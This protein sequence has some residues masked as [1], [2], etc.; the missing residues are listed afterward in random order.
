MSKFHADNVAFVTL[1]L[2]QFAER[3]AKREVLT[4][5]HRIAQAM[6]DYI[7]SHFADDDEHFPQYTANLHDATGVAIYDDG[8]LE[9][10]FPVQRAVDPQQT[11]IGEEEWGSRELEEA[12]RQGMTKF[13]KGLWLVLFS[14][15]SYAESVED[16]GSPK[17][18]GKGFFTWLWET[19]SIDI[20]QEFD[21]CM[22]APQYGLSDSIPF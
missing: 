15:S 17:K 21:G 13:S 18:R 7:D 2:K 22:I 8:R 6:V 4:R 12:A 20:K 3:E 1:K 14:S 10:Y 16:I 5:M 9:N 19:L 11:E